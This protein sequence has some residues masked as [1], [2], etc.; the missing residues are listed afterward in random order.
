MTETPTELGGSEIMAGQDAEDR[1]MDVTDALRELEQS[2]DQLHLG[3]LY[4]EQAEAVSKF[5]GNVDAWHEQFAEWEEF[6]REDSQ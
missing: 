4:P 2:L 3:D 6:L 5:K 1:F